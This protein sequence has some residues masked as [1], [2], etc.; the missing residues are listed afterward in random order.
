MEKMKTLRQYAKAK[1]H[2]FNIGNY[3]Y[4]FLM[5][6]YSDI[7]ENSGISEIQILF[8]SSNGFIKIG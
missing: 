1:K 6:M 3:F 2:H 5:N 8:F 4:K 7:N